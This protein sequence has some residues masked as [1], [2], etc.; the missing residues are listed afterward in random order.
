MSSRDHWNSIYESQ[1]AKSVGWYA[2]HLHA[3]MRYVE[4]VEPRKQAAII[5]VGGGESTLVDDLLGE[6]YLEVTVMDISATALEM[7]RRRLGPLAKYVG[8]K[9]ADVQSTEFQTGQ[10][11]VQHDRAVF[12]FLTTAEQRQRYA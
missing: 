8:W 4:R 7:T 5:D 6:G 11:D 12:H 3:S 1:S 2:E 10:Y 9:V